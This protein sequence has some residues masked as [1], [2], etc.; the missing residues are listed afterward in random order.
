MKDKIAA[1]KKTTE[2]KQI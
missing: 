1:E 2:E